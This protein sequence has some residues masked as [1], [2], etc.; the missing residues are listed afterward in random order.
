[1]LEAG[2]ARSVVTTS[3]DKKPQETAVKIGTAIDH[4]ILKKTPRSQAPVRVAAAMAI[5]R[6][7]PVI[8]I[9][10]NRFCPNAT[11]TN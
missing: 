8:E 10:I 3:I 1:M 2:A 5:Y 4:T 7:A 9:M 6:P 11:E